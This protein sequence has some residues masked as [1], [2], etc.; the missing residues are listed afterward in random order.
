MKT[1]TND[2]P[3]YTKRNRA[4]NILL[5][6]YYNEKSRYMQIKC[7]KYK[8]KSLEAIEAELMASS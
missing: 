5:P 7:V 1:K 4:T 8:I 2:G 6:I 3:F